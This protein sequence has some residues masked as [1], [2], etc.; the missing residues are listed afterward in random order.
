MK[1]NIYIAAD[2]V[3]VDVAHA[4]HAPEMRVGP[5]CLLSESSRPTYSNIKY[6]AEPSLVFK[7]VFC[8][9]KLKGTI[10]LTL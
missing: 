3:P 10:L 1:H 6:H 4:A 5:Q 8:R 9:E 7:R 2:R